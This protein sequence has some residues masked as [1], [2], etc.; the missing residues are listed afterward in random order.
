MANI[1][2]S[3]DMPVKIFCDFTGILTQLTKEHEAPEAPP[4]QQSR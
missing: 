2:I 4:H 1:Q 3:I